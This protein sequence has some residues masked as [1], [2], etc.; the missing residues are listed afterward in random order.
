[1]RIFA[2]LKIALRALRRNKMR[3]L[4]TMLGIIIGVAAVITTVSIGAGARAQVQAQIDSLGRNVILIFSG[5]VSRGGARGGQG[6][7]GTLTLDDAAALRREIPGVALVSPDQRAP[8]QVILGNQNWYTMAMGEGTEYLDIR[9]WPLARGAMF[10][11]QDIRAAN[12][13]AVIGKTVTQQLFGDASPLGQTIRVG[14]VPFVVVGELTPKGN[15]L[16]GEDQDDVVLMPYTSL[17]RRIQGTTNLRGIMAQAQNADQ[18]SQVQQQMTA[19]L[20]QRHRIIGNKEDDFTVRTQQEIAQTASATSR[21]MTILL[22]AI[23]SVS[24]LVGGIGIMNIMLVSVTERTREIGIRMAVGARARTILLQFLL[25]A[26]TLSVIGGAIG[27]GLGVASS[28]VV[29]VNMGWPTLTSFTSGLV[30]FLFSAAVGIFFG[31]Y[32]A[33]KASRMNPI[34]AL[35]YE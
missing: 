35:R 31:F 28:K 22:G 10:T 8:V 29:A 24:L 6:S 32:P 16:R 12:K 9:Q 30:A 14:N 21:I 27:I 18:L 7:A 33:R 11:D 5:S 4:L 26:M 13:V 15:N 1:M 2:T 19:L 23:A 20:R 17:M 34:E 25:E 3:S